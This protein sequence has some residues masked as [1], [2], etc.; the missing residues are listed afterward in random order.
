MTGKLETLAH[1]ASEVVSRMDDDELAMM[2]DVLAVVLVC[3]G[4]FPRRGFGECASE[5]RAR[6]ERC[7]RPAAPILSADCSPP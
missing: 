3:R 6:A 7:P 2:L 1:N 4:I 5:L